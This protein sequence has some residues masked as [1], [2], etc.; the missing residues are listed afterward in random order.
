MWYHLIIFSILPMRLDGREIYVDFFNEIVE[1]LGLKDKLERFPSTLSG[2]QQKRVFIARAL[3]TKPVLIHA[4]AMTTE[5]IHQKLEKV[6]M[7][8]EKYSVGE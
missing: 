7:I 8:Y 5:E 2:G 1:T 6:T 4:D 3:L